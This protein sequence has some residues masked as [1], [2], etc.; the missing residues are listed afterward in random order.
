MKLESKSGTV[1][2]TKSTGKAVTYKEGMNL[3][4]GYTVTTGAK[5][6]ANISIDGT[7]IMKVDASS[8]ISIKKSGKKRRFTS[9]AAAP[10]ST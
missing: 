1:T 8:S 2:I 4:N 3:Y 6:Y 5:S 9:T 7:K 10:A